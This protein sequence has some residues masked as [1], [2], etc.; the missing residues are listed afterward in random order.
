VTATT[1]WSSSS[2]LTDGT[3]TDIIF[4]LKDMTYTSN[5]TGTTVTGALDWTT[6]D[7]LEPHTF[8]NFNSIRAIGITAAAATGVVLLFSVLLITS[9][10]KALDKYLWVAG[11]L[12]TMAFC[13]SLFMLGLLA[14]IPNVMLKTLPTVLGTSFPSIT[15][16]GTTITFGEF[17]FLG[18]PYNCKHIWDTFYYSLTE[19]FF[20][21]GLQMKNSAGSGWWFTLGAM[22]AFFLS[23]ITFS[24]LKVQATGLIASDKSI[25]EGNSEEQ[26]EINHGNILA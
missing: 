17:N 2:N 6:L 8:G 19:S 24:V 7:A 3:G 21:A 4:D 1:K 11:I 16:K 22:F 23:I 25:E 15:C 14:D 13:A 5:I 10:G 9:R 26:H 12:T 20:S 18:E